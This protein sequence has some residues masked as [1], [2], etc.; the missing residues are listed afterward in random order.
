MKAFK[1][2]TADS[3]RQRNMNEQFKLKSAPLRAQLK[4]LKKKLEEYMIVNDLSTAFI[5]TPGETPE[6]TYLQRVQKMQSRRISRDTIIEGLEMFFEQNR[7]TMFKSN[8]EKSAKIWD[9][10]NNARKV[11]KVVMSVLTKPANKRGDPLGQYTHNASKELAKLCTNY[12][13]L[14]HQIKKMQKSKKDKTESLKQSIE[15]QSP[16]IIKSMAEK[17]RKR[18]RI[19]I[20][21]NNTPCTFYIKIK[22][23]ER[24]PALKKENMC[25]LILNSVCLTSKQ[26]DLINHLLEQFDKIPPVR[27]QKVTLDK[28]HYM[29][30]KSV[31]PSIGETSTVLEESGELENST[32]VSDVV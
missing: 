26:E 25:K 3:L 14:F 15:Q 10:I 17:N 1:I 7:L 23:S 27:T 20:K 28:G 5:Q 16:S 2:F 13:Q 12:W 11:D 21:H 18:Q 9:C 31:A 32:V 24:R 29:P 22:V 8:D 30:S 6:T 19:N 4:Q